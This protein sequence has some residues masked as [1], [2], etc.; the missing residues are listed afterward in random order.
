MLNQK[1]KM[2]LQWI[3]GK[4]Y[5]MG[6]LSNNGFY[7][8]KEGPPV[9][10][11]LKPFYMSETTVTNGQFLN[12]VTDT[13]YVTESEHIGRSYVFRSM[14]VEQGTVE[15]NCCS[16]S[17]DWWVDVEGANWRHPEGPI[18]SI[19]DRENH[20]VVHITWNDAQHYATW[21][22]GRLPSEAE[23]EF[24]ARGGLVEKEYP[25]GDELT[26]NAIHQCNIWQGE[27]PHNNTKED[28]YFSTAPVQCFK[29]N[30]YGLY[31]M[32]GNVWEWCSNPARIPLKYFNELSDKRIQQMNRGYQFQEMA[33][34]GGS[35]L[36]HHTYC[37]RY[38][39][40]AR[41]GNTANSAS[42]NCGFRYIID[43]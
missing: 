17:M 1:D 13:G 33:M 20:P 40:A 31:Q 43:V 12:F 26:P 15:S 38:R 21:A 30:G 39:V 28:G 24:S 23:W 5:S 11:Q 36:C 22:G 7:S 42:S 4:T 41:N 18:S 10:I 16:T 8:D 6:T 19:K 37:N 27:F 2:K 25:W 3:P 34:R 35:F 29:P 14:L 9:Q 32:V